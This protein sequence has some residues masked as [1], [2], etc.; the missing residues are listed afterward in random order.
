MHT[1]A[2]THVHARVHTH[3]HPQTISQQ[4][5]SWIS[6]LGKTNVWKW[7]KHTIQCCHVVSQSLY[8]QAHIV[9][10][11]THNASWANMFL[12]FI[13]KEWASMA[14]PW[15]A[16]IWSKKHNKKGSKECLFIMTQTQNMQFS[17]KFPLSIHRMTLEQ[18]INSKNDENERNFFSFLTSFA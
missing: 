3:I 4:F 7:Q 14:A 13:G 5:F 11:Y 6:R 16:Q 10:M 18:Q 2:H 8:W 17:G 15:G 1:L 12:F 9:E